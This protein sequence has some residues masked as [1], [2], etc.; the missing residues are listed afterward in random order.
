MTHPVTFWGFLLLALTAFTQVIEGG[1]FANANAA[2]GTLDSRD[3][4]LQ[5]AHVVVSPWRQHI[6]PPKRQGVAGIERTGKGRLWA[7]YGRDVESTRTFQVVRTSD[8]DGQSWSD[9]RLMI[10][11]RAGT[12]AMSAS[13]WI[14]PNGRLRLFWGQSAGLQ[15]G[16]FGVWTVVCDDPDAVEPQWSAP[17]RT[18]IIRFVER[19]REGR[20]SQTG[21][22]ELGQATGG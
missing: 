21:N 10:L 5:P 14:D 22:Q 17:R 8:D 7:V 9:A 15:D 6:P 20:R 19:S 2:D 4:A 1:K 16:R 12:R 18:E 3:L 11:P 13:I